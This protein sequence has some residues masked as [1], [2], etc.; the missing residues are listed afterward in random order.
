MKK[1]KKPGKY[2]RTLKHG[3][4]CTKHCKFQV[5]IQRDEVPNIIQVYIKVKKKH[6]VDCASPTP[7]PARF[8][9]LTRVRT[10]KPQCIHNNSLG[11]DFIR[12]IVMEYTFIIIYKYVNSMQ[13]LHV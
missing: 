4:C 9:D 10:W 13:T 7:F 2:T 3:R 12:V 6:K 8:R 11:Y 5:S 1:N